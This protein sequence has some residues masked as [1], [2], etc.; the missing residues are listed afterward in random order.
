MDYTMYKPNDT[1][2]T[3]ANSLL[4]KHCPCGV[5]SGNTCPF[6]N[7]KINISCSNEYPHLT[8]Y[9]DVT[10][11]SAATQLWLTAWSGNFGEIMFDDGTFIKTTQPYKYAKHVFPTL[12][13]HWVKLYNEKAKITEIPGGWFEGC[14]RLIKVEGCQDVRIVNYRSFQNCTNLESIDLTEKCK[15]YRTT[16][17]SNCPK[18]TNF[19]HNPVVLNPSSHVLDHQNNGDSNFYNSGV[20]EIVVSG[21]THFDGQ[22][23]FENCKNLRKVTFTGCTNSGFGWAV[24]NGCTALDDF[25]LD[26]VTPP[27]MNAISTTFNNTHCIFYVPKEYFD[28]YKVA[29]NWK[30]F[31]QQGRLKTIEEYKKKRKIHPD[32]WRD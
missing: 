32:V 6:T 18:L 8:L 14:T 29:T 11:T 1:A 23:T 2:F 19:G 17:F 20:Q 3:D 4:T 28:R 5:K 9:Y 26:N 15:D 12:G 27:T 7:E 16:A 31:Y 22:N 24:F 10:T 30:T 21:I 13:I 25:I